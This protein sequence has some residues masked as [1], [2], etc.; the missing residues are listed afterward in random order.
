MQAVVDLAGPSDLLDDGRTK[1]TPYWWRE[2]FISLL[3]HVPAAQ[4]GADLQ[5]ASPVSY[6]APGDP[7]FLIVDSDNDEIV[8]PEQ[9]LE[10]AWDL[11]A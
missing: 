6:V 2:S 10:L 5:E 11:G 3:G 8:Y 7:P 1:A 4:L 9:S